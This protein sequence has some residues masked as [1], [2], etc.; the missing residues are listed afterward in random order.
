[1]SFTDRDYTMLGNAIVKDFD[2]GI[3]LKESLSKLAADQGLNNEEIRRLTETTNTLAHL[4][5]FEK[6]SEADDRYVDFSVVDPEELFPSK[7]ASVTAA[8]SFEEDPSDFHR[9]L[10][11]ERGHLVLEKVAALDPE[12]DIAGILAETSPNDN[13]YS[14]TRGMTKISRLRT[15]NEEL[16]MK[17]LEAN[18]V[19]LEKIAEL[20]DATR[21]TAAENLEYIEKDAYT[22]HGDAVAEILDLVSYESKGHLQHTKVAFDRAQHAVFANPLHDKIAAAM[23][24]RAEVLKWGHARAYLHRVAGPVL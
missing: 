17:I 15:C 11:D 8:G 7:T 1:M 2:N 23:E 19:Y 21:K 5:I 3:P 14:G 24:A 9:E 18:E 16:R 10:P 20:V 22:L 12:L 13:P 4:H 6:M